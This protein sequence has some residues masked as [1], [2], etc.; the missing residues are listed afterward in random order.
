MLTKLLAP[1]ACLKN[2]VK[3]TSKS[4]AHPVDSAEKCRS[5]TSYLGTMHVWFGQLDTRSREVLYMNWLKEIEHQG[6][7]EQEKGRY[8]GAMQHI[9]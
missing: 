4:G 8:M 2:A 7:L 5:R 3:L 9:C 1:L 6:R